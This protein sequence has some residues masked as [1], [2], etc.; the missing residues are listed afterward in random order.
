MSAKF[1]VGEEA[2]Y[3]NIG[4]EAKLGSMNEIDVGLGIGLGIQ[5]G[6]EKG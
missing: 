4:G 5:F 3:G 6:V 2:A 1:L